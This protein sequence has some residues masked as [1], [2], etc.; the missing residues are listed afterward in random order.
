VNP[1][2]LIAAGGT[3]GHIYPALAIA[4]ALQSERPDLEIHFVGT[5]RGLERR[6]I[7][8]QGYPL[9]LIRI[10]RLNRNVSLI[11]RITT[12]ISLPWS[13]V[14]CVLLVLRMRPAF[15]LG[16][17]GYAT[18]PVL[19]AASFLRYRTYIWEPNAHPGLAN[20]IL[21]PFV[22][23]CLLVFDS[24]RF[25]LRGKR[26]R[27]VGMPVREEIA[28]VSR[29][30]RSGSNLK[31]LVFGGSQG[32]RTINHVVRVALSSYPELVSGVEWVHQTGESDFKETQN[33]Y[34]ENGVGVEVRP[35][36]NDMDKRYEWA[37]LVICRGGTGTVSEVAAA[38]RAAL[39]VPLPTAADNHQQRNAEVLMREGAA[40]MCLQVDFTKEYLRQVIVELKMNPESIDQMA[41]SVQKFHRPH[42][43][44]E[45]AHHLLEDI[46]K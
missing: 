37:D 10:G 19:L 7:P 13:I 2:C 18:G 29:W 31:V 24:A 30:R 38:G 22:K 9:H 43:D 16:V 25:L 26:F 40:R 44:R 14:K 6:L 46:S 42:A 15:V 28:R 8:E 17:G 12:V 4:K 20:R 1:V 5:P 3:G 35:Y 32:A 11:E 27:A 39:I 34:S 21:A 23:E 45:I 41:K 36:L 33:F